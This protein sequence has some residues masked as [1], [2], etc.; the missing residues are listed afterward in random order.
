MKRIRA[1][2]CI[3]RFTGPA[4][5]L[6]LLLLFL[7]ME[8]PLMQAG[9]KDLRLLS[10]AADRIRP[11]HRPKEKPKPGDWLAE[12]RESGQTF[13]EYLR[14]RPNRPDGGRTTLYVQ[15]LGEFREDQPVID[16]TTQLL[17]CF[18]GTPTEVLAP[19]GLE[20]IPR[21]ARRVHPSWG[22]RQIL[23]T[24]VLDEVLEPRQP[25]DAVALLALTTSDLWPGKGWN[26]VFGQASLRD[27]VGVWS[28]YRYGDPRRSEED[29]KRF[30]RRVFKV[31][32]HETGHMLGI[33]HC[34][35]HECGMNGS[36]HLR[37]MDGRPLWFCPVC[38][39]KIWWACGTAPSVRYEKLAEFARRHGLEEEAQFW[40]QSHE[41]LRRP[42]SARDSGAAPRNQEGS[43]IAAGA[44]RE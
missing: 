4:F 19:L 22:D 39:Q 42:P 2:R 1:Y 12:H 37:E 11:L 7:A 14:S 30:R 16:D 43:T 32:I 24:Y 35:A 26:F 25:K 29:R 44:G 18:F 15:P 36:N 41:R 34:T 27:R 20:I 33:R 40:K 3:V 8:G 38:V 13:A 10:Q 5:R 28:L 6:V 9:E 23:S 17:A 21:K 31:A